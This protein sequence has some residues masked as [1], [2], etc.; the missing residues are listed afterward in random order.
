[1]LYHGGFVYV[2]LAAENIFAISDSFL[3]NDGW[4]EYVLCDDFSLPMCSKILDREGFLRRPPTRFDA[5]GSNVVLFRFWTTFHILH[6]QKVWRGGIRNSH[7]KSKHPFCIDFDF[8]FRAYDHPHWSVRSVHII[9]GP[10]LESMA[11][12]AK[13]FEKEGGKSC[14][15]R[16]AT[17]AGNVQDGE[18]TS[19]SGREDVVNS[20]AGDLVNYMTRC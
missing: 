11:E 9:F 7:D 4:C 10:N 1:M 20:Q 8:N 16:T 6:H 17:R 3:P 19:G 2:K 14:R 18:A 12:E 5:H 15:T 13:D